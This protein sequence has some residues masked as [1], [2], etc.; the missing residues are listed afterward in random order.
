MAYI[1]QE[2]KKELAPAIKAVLKKYNMK[3]TISVNNHSTLVVTLKEGKF[4]FNKDHFGVNTYWINEH[5]TGEVKDFFNEL[6]KAMKGTGW[7]DRSDAMTDYFD[8]AYYIDINVGRWNKPYVCTE[9][10]AA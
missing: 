8:T 2:R 5:Y 7:Y 4:K 9:L 3:G 10:E 1:N 6:V